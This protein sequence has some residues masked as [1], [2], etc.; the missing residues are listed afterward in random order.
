MKQPKKL[1]RNQKEV[2]HSHGYNV[3]EWMLRK[4]TEFKLYLVHK[5]TGKRIT[6]DNFI[7]GTKKR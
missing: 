3:D 4:E 6:V 1:T 5:S 7:R 2:V